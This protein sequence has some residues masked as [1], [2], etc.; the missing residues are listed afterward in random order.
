MKNLLLLLMIFISLDAFAGDDDILVTRDG[1]LTPV[2]IVKISTQEVTYIDL[3][4][5]KRQRTAPTSTVYMIMKEKGS[6]IFFDEEGNQMTSPVV[7]IDKKDNVMFTND[8]KIFPIYEVSIGKDAVSYK[9]QDKKKAEVETMNKSDIFMIRNS[10]GT[11][12]VFTAPPVSQQEAPSTPVSTI[13]N[14]YVQSSSSVISEPQQSNIVVDGQT[15]TDELLAKNAQTIANFNA[16]QIPYDGEDEG[17]SYSYNKGG[18]LIYKYAFSQNSILE[19]TDLT[20][21]YYVGNFYTSQVLG[22]KYVDAKE[23]TDR[24]KTKGWYRRQ[25]L[26]ISL[27]NKT[28][29]VIFIDLGNTYL[30]QIGISKPYYVPSATSVTKGVSSGVG[31]NMGAVA[32]A[33]GV[34]GALGTLANGVN[35]GG[36]T[37]SETTHVTYSQRIVSIPPRST[38]NLTPK[39]FTDEYCHQLALFSMGFLHHDKQR[40]FRGGISGKTPEIYYG[41]LF[42]L[43]SNNSPQLSVFITY[44]FDENLNQT[45][46][47][48]ADLYPS[49]LL[50]TNSGFDPY[51]MPLYFKGVATFRKSY[52]RDILGE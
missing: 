17:K 36:G 4:K 52:L 33:L 44:G 22:D 49:Q 41:E 18:I 47:I 10:D 6:N 8:G 21:R 31:V 48:M 25:G 40:E 2:K 24:R 5:K 46:N 30:S 14:N 51:S 45:S 11:T 19:N 27:T 38:I 26:G 50:V 23:Q 39:M 15:M 32:G 3:S 13:N 16:R 9:L 43:P 35:V 34:G 28:N 1:S 37:S 12:T 29:R 42:D 20:T 7:K